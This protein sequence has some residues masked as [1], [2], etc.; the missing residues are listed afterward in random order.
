M[1]HWTLFS[2]PMHKNKQSGRNR[3]LE[4]VSQLT[5]VHDYLDLLLAGP[6]HVTVIQGRL[7]FFVWS[8]RRYRKYQQNF[9]AIRKSRNPKR[10]VWHE[11]RKKNPPAP[12]RVCMCWPLR[13]RGDAK[14]GARRPLTLLFLLK[15][16]AQA[17]LKLNWVQRKISIYSHMS[18][19]RSADKSISCFGGLVMSPS[20][21]LLRRTRV[22]RF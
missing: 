3:Q 19:S 15:S 17:G 21:R 13:T 2:A 16:D 6:F 1:N 11:R 14:M 22:F 4:G 5:R 8:R 10:A 18:S 9:K 7:C 12:P 20:P